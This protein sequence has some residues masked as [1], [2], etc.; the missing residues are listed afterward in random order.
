MAKT[1]TFTSNIGFYPES[2][3]HLGGITSLRGRMI[4]RFWQLA[5]RVLLLQRGHKTL[6]RTTPPTTLSWLNASCCPA[7]QGF[8][9]S[10]KPT[11]INQ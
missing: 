6:N 9:V 5:Q 8:A 11:A 2:F 1:I 3:P 4:K 7:N 10:Q